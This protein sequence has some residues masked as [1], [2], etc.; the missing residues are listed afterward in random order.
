M[1][2]FWMIT[3]GVLLAVIQAQV[4]GRSSLRGIRY[5]RSFDRRECCAGDEIELVEVIANEKRLPVPLLKLEAEFPTAFVFRG[6]PSIK[7]GKG[8]VYQTHTSGFALLPMRRV[9]RR[10]FVTCAQRGI[11]RLSTVFMTSGDLLGFVL[12]SRLLTIESPLIVYPRLLD[13]AEV[14]HDWKSWQGDFAVRRWILADPFVI[15]GSREY[16]SGDPMNRIHWKASARTGGLQVYRQG[17]TADPQVMIVLDIGRVVLGL[18]DNEAERLA[19]YAVSL[20]ATCADRLLCTGVQTG[21]AHNAHTVSL[22]RIPPGAGRAQRAALMEAMA[23]IKL[24]E[25]ITLEEYLL[26]EARGGENARDYIVV[27]ASDPADARRAVQALESRG[28]R[29]SFIDPRRGMAGASFPAESGGSDRRSGETGAS[30]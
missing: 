18:A 4:I 15:E 25:R 21:F 30:T 14:P 20:A 29:I 2:L 16:S 19:E 6:S 10:H 11:F 7:V 3:I 9:K 22:P 28:H 24:K 1:T 8:S 12:R 17:Y 5:S 23:G 26:E 13:E 27:S